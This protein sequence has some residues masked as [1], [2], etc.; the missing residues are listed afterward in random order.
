MTVK[1]VR[2]QFVD[3]IGT[4]AVHALEDG[5]TVGVLFGLAL[6]FLPL[7]AL[8]ASILGVHPKGN[9]PLAIIRGLG[10]IVRDEAARKQES[11]FV[12]A[13]LGGSLL[14]AGTGAALSVAA[15]WAGVSVPTVAALL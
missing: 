5:A 9:G 3:G 7:A 12:A 6:T 8:L 14:G 1:A 11:Y 2:Q 10:E 15:S 13:T 4:K